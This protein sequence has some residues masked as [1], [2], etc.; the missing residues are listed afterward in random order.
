MQ[1]TEIHDELDRQRERLLL[2]LEPLPDEALTAPGVMDDWSVADILAHLVAWESELV[3]CLMHINQGKRPTQML[4]AIADVDGYNARRFQE[5]Q[6][7]PL[8]AIFDDLQ[9]VR[10]QLEQWL[11]EFSERDLNDLQRYPWAEG[12]I[13]L[14]QIIEENSFGHEAEHLPAIEAFAARWPAKQP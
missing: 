4:A 6:G 9:G 11:E 2:A 8:D 1:A 5:N 12:R 7:R 3:T 10:L 13:T 14:A